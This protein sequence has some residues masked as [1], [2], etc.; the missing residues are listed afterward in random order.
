MNHVYASGAHAAAVARARNFWLAAA[1]VADLIFSY[2][3]RESG[4]SKSSLSSL[5]CGMYFPKMVKV[6]NISLSI[7]YSN[8]LQ[9]SYYAG[10]FGARNCMHT[11]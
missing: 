6:T 4:T 7:S 10:N 9:N 8:S 11:Y 5:F 1:S 2:D 3:I